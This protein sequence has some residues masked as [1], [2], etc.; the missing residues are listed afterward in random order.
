METQMIVR[1]DE[2]LKNKF[3]RIV[4]LEGKSQSVK[5]RELIREYVE[6]NDMEI[7]VGELWDRIGRKIRKQYSLK[8]VPRII[9]DVRREKRGKSESGD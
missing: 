3:T 1:I 9:A 7:Y 4:K 2:E 5:T 8:D 6:K